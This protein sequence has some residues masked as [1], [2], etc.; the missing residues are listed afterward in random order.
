MFLVPV[1]VPST[2]V[3]AWRR[4]K[5]RVETSCRTNQTIYRW[6]VCVCEYLQTLYLLHQREC[7]VLEQMCVFLPDLRNASTVTLRTVG[8]DAAGDSDGNQT[9]R[10][11]S[12]GTGDCLYLLCWVLLFA[13]VHISLHFQELGNVHRRCGHSITRLSFAECQPCA[14][15]VLLPQCIF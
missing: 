1:F 4:T 14:T 9:A 10:S 15:S 3:M 11:S 7:F 6:V 13:T 8:R 12:D 5:F 2:C